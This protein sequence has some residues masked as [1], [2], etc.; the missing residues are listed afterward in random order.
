M[1][2]TGKM[3]IKSAQVGKAC[4]AGGADRSSSQSKSTNR[5]TLNGTTQRTWARMGY[6]M[7]DLGTT[8]DHQENPVRLWPYNRIAILKMQVVNIS[9]ILGVEKIFLSGTPKANYK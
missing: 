2:P 4:T 6:S 1:K 9:L 5:P 7:S 8:D 3:C